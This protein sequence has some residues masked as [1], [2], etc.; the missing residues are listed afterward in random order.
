MW[1]LAY[2]TK[3]EYLAALAKLAEENEVLNRER[4][5]RDYEKFFHKKHKAYMG[6]TDII[7]LLPN[8]E[9]LAEQYAGRSY[10]N[11]KM[12]LKSGG[13]SAGKRF[14]TNLGY[15][16]VRFF[17]LLVSVL[18]ILLIVKGLFLLGLSLLVLS[19]YKEIVISFVSTIMLWLPESI[20]APVKDF[21]P[22][23]FD[24]IFAVIFMASVGVFFIF[25]F[26]LIL[27]AFLRINKK[28]KRWRLIKISGCFRLPIYSDDLYSWPWR[29]LSYVFLPLSLIGA[30]VSGTMMF[31]GFV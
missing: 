31:F 20:V 17:S 28:I 12:L 18:S 22:G 21:I 1:E 30:I 4:M 5:L 13:I 2:K 29:I 24:N 9:Q 6:D 14:Q 27:K 8:P 23:F 26:S 25:F 7:G 15:W 11:T 10:T 3:E 19:G 16:I